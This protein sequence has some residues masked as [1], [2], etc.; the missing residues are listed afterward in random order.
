MHEI[1]TISPELYSQFFLKFQLSDVFSLFYYILLIPLS[2]G[3]LQSDPSAAAAAAS[4]KGQH[5]V[6]FGID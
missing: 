6:I 1:G 2:S 4:E 3:G 5:V